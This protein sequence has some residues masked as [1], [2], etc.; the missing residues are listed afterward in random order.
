MGGKVEQSPFSV[1]WLVHRIAREHIA[2]AAS[3]H[4]SGRVLDIGCGRRPYEQLLLGHASSYIGL[5]SNRGR[6]DATAAD[7]WGSALS[8]PLRSASVDTVVAFQVLEHVP[9]PAMLFVESYRVLKPGGRLIVTAPHIW[10]VH[11]E[12]ED[13]FRFTGYGLAH[14]SRQAG[15][16]V[17][18]VRAMAGYW[19]TAGSRLCYYLQHFEKIGLA[20]FVR[21]LYAVIQLAALV[22]D[23]LHRVEG[24]TWNFIL[25]ASKEDDDA[26]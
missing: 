26:H 1:S 13:Y 24:D 15:L 2:A 14:L 6:Y 9:D 3:R 20:V 11:E 7:I 23:R 4:A 8:L 18:S 22:L 17:D 10:G 25:V 16:T 12:P 5:E 19:V 21:P